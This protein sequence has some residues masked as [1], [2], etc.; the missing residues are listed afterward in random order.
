[1]A[2]YTAVGAKVQYSTTFGTA[3]TV[4]SIS[5]ATTAVA[6]ATAHGFSDGDELL[7][8]NGWE[9]ASDAIWRADDVATNALDLEGLDSSDSDWFPAGAASAGTLQKVS[10]WVDIG[11]ILEVNNTGG[12]RRDITIN[13]LSRRNGLLIPIGF[14]A[15]GIDFTLGWDP[16]KTD[17][18]DLDKISRRLSQKVAFRFLLAGGA[19]L[20]AYGQLSKSAIPLMA[21]GDVMKTNISI[22]FLGMVSTYVD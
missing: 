9:D 8:I 10:S 15:S 13:P 11:Q 17:Q 3:K 7:L 20:Y 18:Q 14:E 19:K 5:N 2:Y 4:T 16:A 21:S 12:G 1:M 22:N 6:S